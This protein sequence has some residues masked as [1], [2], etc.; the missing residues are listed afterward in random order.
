LTHT[1]AGFYREKWGFFQLPNFSSSAWEEIKKEADAK[2]IPLQKGRI[3]GSDKDPKMIEACLENLK[4]AGFIE[5]IELICKDVRSLFPA[6]PPTLI[7]SNPPYGKRIT[8]ASTLYSSLEYFLKRKCAP[9]HRAFILSPEKPNL[10]I[11]KSFPF[12]NGGFKIF[13]FEAHA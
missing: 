13:L 1:P 6:A 11:K 10:Q 9:N 4:A 3:F 7:V 8:L 5:N 12:T 2:I